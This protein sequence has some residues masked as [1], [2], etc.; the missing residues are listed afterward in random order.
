MSLQRAVGNF[1]FQGLLESADPRT[2]HGL[3]SIPPPVAEVVAGGGRPLEPGVS[4]E[5]EQL[6]GADLGSVRVHDDARAAASADAIDAQAY[7]AG[8]HVVFGPGRY[9]PQTG[10]GRRL[11]AHEVGHV[12]AGRAGGGQAPVQRQPKDAS[13]VRDR[14][15][16]LA[17][18][19]APRVTQFASTTVA[20]IYFARDAFLMEPDGF[21][22]VQQLGRQLSFMAK[23]MVV[24]DGFASS[25]GTEK[26]N[27]E[28]GRLRRD[29]VVAVLATAARGVT[30]GGRGHGAADPAVP[31][32]ATD[33]KELEAQRAQNRRASIAIM[34]LSAPAPS[35]GAAVT[36]PA[37]DIFKPIRPRDETEQER[38]NRG[39]QQ[40]LKLPADLRPPSKSLSEQA[41][42]FFD[43]K[44]DKVLSSLGVPK[45][46][47]EPI[48]KAA[49]AGVEKG[50]DAGLDKALEAAGVTGQAKEAAKAALKAAAATKP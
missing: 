12:V 23:P 1:A 10:E 20:T 27:E 36:P 48:K 47:R 24:V 2:A 45:E 9:R 3:S 40:S 43:E 37:V 26:R 5:L 22:A 49:L 8:E 21:A 11:L 14:V 35:A 28:L 34:D 7:A 15:R 42:R 16:L 25:E 39:I 31:E 19:P 46:F 6:V 29:A 41:R 33:P 30:I 13:T 38:V 50:I 4:A 17:G 32:T 44:A 18:V